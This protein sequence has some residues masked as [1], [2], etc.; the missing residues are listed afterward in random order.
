MYGAGF[1]CPQILVLSCQNLLCSVG[2]YRVILMTFYLEAGMGMVMFALGP[3][4]YYLLALFLTANLILIQ[5][6]FSLFGL[7]LADII[8]SDLTKYKRSCPLSSMVFGTNAL[9]TKPSQSLAPMIVLTILNQFGYEQLKEA[10]NESKQ[11]DLENL[12]NVMFSLVCLVPLAIA[13]LQI[14]FF[15]PF[16]IRESHTVDIKYIDS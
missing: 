16:S 1:I 12:H 11:S 6:A 3:Q 7:P 13:V 4:H 5:A 14:V 15:K 10:S 2:Y 9:F 8:D